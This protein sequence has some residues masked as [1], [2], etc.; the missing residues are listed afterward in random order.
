[1]LLCRM[2]GGQV[3]L[4]NGTALDYD[5]LVLALGS[6][7]NT[8]GTPGAREHAI[9]FNSLQ[10]VQQV[11]VADLRSD[12]AARS[13]ISSLAIRIAHGACLEN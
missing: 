13:V 3:I 1:M 10:D 7:T 8:F 2:A 9:T 11:G 4:G 12:A 6:E 5:W